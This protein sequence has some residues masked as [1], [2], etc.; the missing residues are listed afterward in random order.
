MRYKS[1][2]SRATDIPKA[3]KDRV[4]ERDGGIC[5]FCGHPGLPEAHCIPRA[6]GGLGV[7]QNVVTA[8]R[9]CHDA[10]DNGKYGGQFRV[11][12][13]AYLKKWY[14]D[15]DETKLIYKKGVT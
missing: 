8:C 4:Y 14:P 9:V 3:V 15:W 12:A 2:R 13:K 6:Q 7:E 1:K 5:I 10:M 11:L